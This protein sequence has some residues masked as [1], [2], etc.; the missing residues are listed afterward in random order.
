MNVSGFAPPE[1]LALAID[2]APLFF[3][4]F[5]F[6]TLFL[7]EFVSIQGKKRRSLQWKGV[8]INELI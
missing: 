5:L 6:L 4:S 7:F 1:R 2:A 8:A 3:A